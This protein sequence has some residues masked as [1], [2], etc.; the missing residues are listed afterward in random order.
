MSPAFEVA[1]HFSSADR[2][3][4][5]GILGLADHREMLD[6][7]RAEQAPG[8]LAGAEPPRR[9]EQ[10]R[11]QARRVGRNLVG[12]AGADRLDRTGPAPT[13][14]LYRNLGELRF[15][16]VT[17]ESGISH[18]GWGQGVCAGDY[19]NDGNVDLFL[20]EWGHNVLFRNRGDGR[21]EDVTER[22]GLKMPAKRWSTGC[23]FLDYDRDGLLDLFVAHY[24]NFDPNKTPKPGEKSECTWKGIPVICGPRGLPG[25]TMSLFRNEGKSRF[26]DV[27]KKA[28]IE[29]PRTYYGFTA[30]TADF[31]NDGWTD[32]YVAGDSTAVTGWRRCTWPPVRISNPRSR[33]AV[34]LAPRATKVTACPRSASMPP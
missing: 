12:P 16:E 20:T 8:G 33:R 2:S 23:A 7:V 25:E 24:V 28:G 34:R 27:S 15:K 31:E 11:R 3:A 10:V 18:T 1:L 19:D 6:E 13:H 26:V 21:F 29:G 22:V 9:L 14:H 17:E 30:L 5:G 4:Q 32:I